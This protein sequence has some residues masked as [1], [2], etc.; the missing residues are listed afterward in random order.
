MLGLRLG[1][2]VLFALPLAAKTPE[3]DRAHELAN[4]EKFKQAI[5][6]L[7]KAP[8]NDAD[9]LELLGECYYGVKDYKQAVEVLE[10]AV[11]LAPKSSNAQLWLGRAW[12]RRAESN[13]LMGFSWARKTRDAL[14][15]AVVLDPR[16]SEALD[17]LFE[18]Y[19]EAPGIVGGG[20]EKAEGV[21]KRIIQMDKAWGEKLLAKVAARKK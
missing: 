12:G 11:E 18:F 20:L 14:E 21:A 5:A 17:D 7:E 10:Q 8:R 13:K 19:L 1:V 6:I 2:L 9:N 16:N 3:W 15:K 4:G